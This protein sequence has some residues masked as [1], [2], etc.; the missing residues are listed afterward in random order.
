MDTRNHTARRG[1]QPLD[2]TK[3]EWTLLECLMRHPGQTLSRRFLLDYV[4]SYAA[5]VQTS[6]VDV[7]ISYLRAKLR[8]P[9]MKDPIQTKRGFGYSLDVEHA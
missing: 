6:M 1:D 4:W 9:E 8:L 5:D 3:T 2:L 7:Y